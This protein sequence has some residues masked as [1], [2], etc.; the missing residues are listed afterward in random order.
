[1]FEVPIDIFKMAFQKK[2]DGFG[3]D[4]LNLESFN[5]LKSY[6]TPKNLQ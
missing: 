1:M 3:N 2:L 6:I 5:L 4:L